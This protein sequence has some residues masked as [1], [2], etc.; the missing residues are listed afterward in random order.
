MT[1]APRVKSETP[2]LQATA[3]Q[4]STV[5][6]TFATLDGQGNVSPMENSRH[7]KRLRVAVDVD[8]GAT[9][10]HWMVF[11]QLTDQVFNFAERKHPIGILSPNNV[12]N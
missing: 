3:T 10:M 9:V 1:G 2:K 8:E 4:T 12:V 5:L 6:P 7:S 11:F